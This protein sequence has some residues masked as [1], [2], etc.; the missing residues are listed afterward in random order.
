MD[1]KC[2]EDFCM[3]FEY[4]LESI[5]VEELWNYKLGTNGL[6]GR[7]QFVFVF[8]IFRIGIMGL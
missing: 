6:V 5:I 8:S 2:E 3:I 4:L 1:V 7:Y